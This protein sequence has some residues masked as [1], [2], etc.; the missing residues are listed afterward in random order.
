MPVYE[1]R[2]KGCNKEFSLTLS[3]REY[4]AQDYS[5][6]GCKGKDLERAYSTLQ[7]ITSKKS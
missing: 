1:F 2:C 3:L 6:P 7:V 4:E 5:C